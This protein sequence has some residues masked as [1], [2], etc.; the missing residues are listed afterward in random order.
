[1]GNSES[2]LDV[3]VIDCDTCDREP[4]ILV[5]LER[6]ERSRNAFMKHFE[7]YDEDSD[8]NLSKKEVQQIVERKTDPEGLTIEVFVDADEVFEQF[9]TNKDGL[10]D[11]TEFVSYYSTV[12]MGETWMDEMKAEFRKKFHDADTNQDNKLDHDELKDML[13]P[14]TGKVTDN[15]LTDIFEGFDLNK[16]QLIEY[17]ESMIG[18]I[19]MA[20]AKNAKKVEHLTHDQAHYGGSMSYFTKQK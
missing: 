4:G 9:D 18:L 14:Y 1:M 3:D 16:N 20:Y 8:G 12:L 6:W 10:I 13:K 19:T 17:D 5:C 2:A 7:T 11:Y 15:V